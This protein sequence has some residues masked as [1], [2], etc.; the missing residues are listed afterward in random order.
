MVRLIKNP[1]LIEDIGN[2][3]YETVKVNYSLKKS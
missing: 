1:N 2:K 3:L